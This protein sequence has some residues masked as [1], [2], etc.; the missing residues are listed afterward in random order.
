MIFAEA[1][2]LIGAKVKVAIDT[3]MDSFEK[4]LIILGT[5]T[6]LTYTGQYDKDG[7]KANNITY[8]VDIVDPVT[9]GIHHVFSYNCYP[10][11]TQESTIEEV[12]KTER[13]AYLESELAKLG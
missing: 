9:S 8:H 12:R 13:K 11:S 7:E 1:K 10:E 2:L 6:K 4:G 3:E 5:L